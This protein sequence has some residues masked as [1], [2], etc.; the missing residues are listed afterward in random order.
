MGVFAGPDI[1]ESGLVLALDAGNSKSYPGTGTTW[2]DLSGRGING[3]LTNMDGTNF[4]SANGG[5]LTFD[6]TNEFVYRSLFSEMSS[7][8]II[9]T[10]CW[11]TFADNGSPGRTLWSI[12]RD[13]GGL[14]GIAIVSYGFPVY[15]GANKLGFEF[16]TAQG[17]VL[18][19][20]TLQQN[21][22][23][24]IA[25]TADRS[26]TKIYV[27]GSLDNT[28]SQGS[29]TISSSP[30]LSVGSY[31]SASIPPTPGVYF[32]NGKIS[33]FQVYNRTLT[34]TEIRQNFNA[35]KSRYF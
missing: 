22:W 11:C 26:N 10:S 6:G 7:I 12:G 20:G 17:R 4:N 35:T 18:Y 1:V 24:N 14:G 8:Q 13:T 28:A 25:I 23:Y 9:S 27:N 34:A 31:L 32:H 19:T 21:I 2:T 33:N 5:S 30:G 29:G 3:T 16:G 15:G